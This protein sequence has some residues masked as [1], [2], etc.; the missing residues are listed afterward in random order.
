MC[1]RARALLGERPVGHLRNSG[2]Y[3]VVRDKPLEFVVRAETPEAIL[4]SGS[5][6]RADLAAN[7][8]GWP[9]FSVL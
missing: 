1:T 3:L 9:E 6:T 2:F 7:T 8:F 4:A 5:A